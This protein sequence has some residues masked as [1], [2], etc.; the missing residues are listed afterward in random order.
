MRAGLLEKGDEIYMVDGVR[1]SDESH[2][3]QLLTGTDIPFSTVTLKVRRGPEQSKLIAL[4]RVPAQ[5]LTDRLQLFEEFTQVC[6]AS[7]F[8]KKFGKPVLEKMWMPRTAHCNSRK[9]IRARC[10]IAGKVQKMQLSLVMTPIAGC[11]S[12]F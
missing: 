4:K 11:Q 7:A 3:R 2:L 1:V 6:N 9:S 5:T 12:G 10:K 8:H